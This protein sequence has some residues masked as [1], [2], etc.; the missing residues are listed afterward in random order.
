MAVKLLPYSLTLAR[1][2]ARLDRGAG[3]LE[4][5]SQRQ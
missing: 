1:P 4:G 3:G 5:A 2:R